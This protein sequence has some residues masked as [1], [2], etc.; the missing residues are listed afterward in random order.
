MDGFGRYTTEEMT[1]VMEL[2]RRTGEPIPAWPEMRPTG[3]QPVCF[4]GMSG[5][6]GRGVA[7]SF[8]WKCLGGES[9]EVWSD[10]FNGPQDLMPPECQSGCRIFEYR[11]HSVVIALNPMDVTPSV[12][13]AGVRY[14]T[15]EMFQHVLALNLSGEFDVRVYRLKSDGGRELLFEQDFYRK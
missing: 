10:D 1:T 6:D 15:E 7:F 13:I 8:D 12:L 4:A 9:I 2:A 14:R 5:L 11:E 3:M